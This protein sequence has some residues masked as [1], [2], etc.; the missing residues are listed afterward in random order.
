M[1]N[2]VLATFPAQAG[3]LENLKNL[4]REKLVETRA[5][6]GCL[7]I[8]VY[9]EE[10]TETIHLVEDWESLAHY[11]KYLQWRI[12][13]GLADLL[14][15]TQSSKAGFPRS[16]SCDAGGKKTS[17]HAVGHTRGNAR[18]SIPSHPVF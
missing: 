14:C 7:S 10:G 8:E 5:F 12:E 9:V 2:L 17:S 1:N 6:E 18:R 4:F 3:K 16:R 13:T 11:E 15:S